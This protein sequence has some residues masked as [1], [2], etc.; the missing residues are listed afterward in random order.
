MSLGS[1]AFQLYAPNYTGSHL[2]DETPG[3]MCGMTADENVLG[4]TNWWYRYQSTAT[5]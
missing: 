5:P 4:A 3:M 2:Y 1:G